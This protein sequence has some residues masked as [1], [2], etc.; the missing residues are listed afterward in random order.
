MVSVDHINVACVSVYDV[1]SVC[2][3]CVCDLY[4]CVMCD[5]GMCGICISVWYRGLYGVCLCVMWYV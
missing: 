2:G 4:Q 1:W 5:M 3:A